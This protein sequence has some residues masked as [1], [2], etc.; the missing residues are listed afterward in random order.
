[1]KTIGVSRWQIVAALLLLSAANVMSQSAGTGALTGTVTDPSGAA[2]PGVMVTLANKETGQVRTT[3][4]GADGNYRFALLP[5][6]T[7]QVKFA[8]MG[9][10][11]AEVPSITVNVTE[12]PVLNRALEVGGQTETVLVEAEAAALQTADSTLGTVVGERTVTSLPLTSRNYTQILG[13]SAGTAVGVTDASQLGKGTQNISVNGADPGQNNFQMDGVAINNTANS[14]SSNDGTIYAGIA[15]PNPD[16]I[17]EFKVQTSTY[18]ASYG[19]NPGGNVNVVTKSGTNQFHGAAFEF[20]RNTALNANSF[21]YNRD[22][23]NSSKRKQILNQNQFGGAVGG[24]IKKDKIFFFLS[25]Q[26]TRQKNGVSSSGSSSV[27]LPPLPAGDRSSPA[28]RA[29]LGAA[30]CPDNQPAATRNR[31]TTVNGGVQVACDGSNISPVALNIL[32]LKLPNGAYYVPSSGASGFL[33]VLNSNPARFSEHQGVANV[34]FLINSKNTLSARFF[35]SNDPQTMAFANPTALPG[36]PIT[37]LFANTDAV[38]K[39]TTLATNTFVNEARIS[40]QRNFQQGTD[41]TPWSAQQ[42]GM[43]PM[44]PSVTQIAP[45]TVTGAFSMFG[46]VYP[47]FSTTNQYQAADQISWTHGKHTVRAGFEYEKVHWPIVHAGLQRGLMS[48]WSFADF[49][50]GRAGCDPGDAACGAQNP[51]LTNGTAFSNISGCLFCVRSGPNGII[52]GYFLSDMYAYVQDDWKVNTRLTLNL[53]VRWEFDG[54]LHDK[55]GN[56]TNFW[57][58]QIGQVE[59]PP[60]GPNNAPAGLLGYV[61]PSNYTHFYPAPPDGVLINSKDSPVRNGPPKDNFAPRVGFAWQPFDTGRFVVRG[62]FGIFYDR[63]GLDRLVHGLEQGYPYAVTLDYNG[64]ATQPYSLQNPYPATPVPGTFAARWANFTTLRTSNLNTPWIVENLHTPLVRQY[65]LNLQYEFVKDW[66]LELGYVGASGINLV[67]QYH[68]YNTASFASPSQP[69]HGITTNTV[70]N[71][72]FRVPYLGYQ[73]G[74]FQGT[75]FDGVYN[76]NS[77]QA[78]VR[79]RFSQGFTMQASYTWSKDLGDVNS[80]AGISSNSANS[81]NASDLWQQYGPVWYNRP[82]R[83]IVNY[84][85]ELPFNKFHGIADK[86]AN[87]WSISGVT[88]AQTGQPL[89]LTDARAGT[90]FGVTGA[91]GRVQMCP[92]ATYGSLASPGGVEQR[93]GG[94]SRG[95]GYFNASAICPPPA[96][97]NGTGYGNSGVGIITGP[98]QFNW[99]F[100]FAK[101]TKITERQGVQFRAE[102]FNAFNHPQF[103]NPSLSASSPTTFGVIGSTSVNP[104]LIQFALKYIF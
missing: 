51:G 100:T 77:L 68:N 20:F 59:F 55:Y 44:L 17:Q 48:T 98:G 49:L 63:V 43:T 104:R 37:L 31:F 95:P 29:A 30:M 9:F 58:S 80:V 53:G 69:I 79:K 86:L 87:G 19:R 73:P 28:W 62:G 35:H 94:G 54:T 3:E 67:D 92:D 14:G 36:T 102:F 10:K 89:T 85:Y 38:L 5:P 27:Q 21:F 88:T 41:G 56:L 47:T 71:V 8:A 52:H 46:S 57:Q 11:T 12:T 40:F 83:F 18:D 34:D 74:G 13:L 70:Q 81:N 50:I 6:G 22:N 66:V 33:Q 24:P 25:E 103:N 91:T 99:D 1:M 65:N 2:I 82:H 93:L 16:A 4:T 26:E 60:S 42:V 96:I 23:P 39:L 84:S 45:L 78:T 72:A 97:G 75:A 7:Y 101:M 61:V 76:Y 32:Q 15:V 90:I 64:T